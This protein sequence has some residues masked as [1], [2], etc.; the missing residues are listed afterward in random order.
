MVPADAWFGG[1]QAL[2]QTGSSCN[3]RCF[4]ALIFHFVTSHGCWM[5]ENMFKLSHSQPI[6]FLLGLPDCLLVWSQWA[7]PCGLMDKASVSD[8]GDCRFKSCQGREL[9]FFLFDQNLFDDFENYQLPLQ[10][11]NFQVKKQLAGCHSSL[12]LQPIFHDKSRL[13]RKPLQQLTRFQHRWNGAIMD[14][15]RQAWSFSDKDV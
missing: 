12:N 8:T 2:Q 3:M 4:W 11:W 6:N 7:R 15:G 9:I 5:E 1:H 10:S 13:Y 14:V